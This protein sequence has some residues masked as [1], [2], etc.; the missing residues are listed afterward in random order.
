M[1]LPLL[2]TLLP[3]VSHAETI[4][5]QAMTGTGFAINRS[6]DIITNAHVV[7]RC[8]SIH[9][10]KNHEEIPAQIIA[11]DDAHDLVL[12]RAPTLNP[13]NNAPLR[14][15]IEDIRVGDPVTMLG[16]PGGDGAKGISR[17]KKTRIRGLEGPGGEPK[18]LQL[19]SVA[20]KGNSGGPV[21]DSAGNVI[22]VISGIAKVFRSAS[23]QSA[24]QLVAQTDVAITL[25]T[26]QTFLRDY[27]VS[28]NEA[29][30]G[31]LIQGDAQL[32][33]RALTFT[34]PVRCVLSRTVTP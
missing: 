28:Y 11:T 17:F 7:R 25:P 15:N 8:E 16:Y 3:L 34:F 2:L 6:G 20:E 32:E 31:L 33:Q 10:L 22:A 13:E 14:W 9:L 1:R 29:S 4:T 12:L 18:W 26:L 23:G 27:R 5:T 19:E 21:L 30:S 24:Q